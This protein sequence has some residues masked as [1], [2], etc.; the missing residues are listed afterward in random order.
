[1]VV[2]VVVVVDHVV[3]VALSHPVH[4]GPKEERRDQCAMEGISAKCSFLKSQQGDV[5][6]S[7]RAHY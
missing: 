1:M 3:A 2:L 7:F 4:L 5:L 6:W